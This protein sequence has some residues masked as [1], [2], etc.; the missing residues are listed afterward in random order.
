[1][2]IRSADENHENSP[3]SIGGIPFLMVR[4]GSAK[5]LTPGEDLPQTFICSLNDSP[6]MFIM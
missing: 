4:G 1:M 2:P 6:I 3:G 5:V